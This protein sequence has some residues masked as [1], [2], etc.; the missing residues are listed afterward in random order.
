VSA[1]L[2]IAAAALIVLAVTFLA[3]AYAIQQDRRVREIE[4]QRDDENN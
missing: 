2:R 4:Q 1:G 3:L